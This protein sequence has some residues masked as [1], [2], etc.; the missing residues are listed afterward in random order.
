METLVRFVSPTKA[1]VQTSQG[2][3]LTLGMSNAVPLQLQEQ[4]AAVIAF[5]FDKYYNGD[6]AVIMGPIFREMMIRHCWSH[7][8]WVGPDRDNERE[9]IGAQIRTL[10]EQRHMDARDL[11]Q[12]A[13]LDASNL[14]RIEKGKYSAGLDILCKIA[15]ALNCTLEFVPDSNRIDSLPQPILEYEHQD[16]LITAKRSTFLL[17]E[18]L[19]QFGSFHWQQT[20]YNLHKGD[21]VYVYMSE[22]RLIKYKMTVIEADKPYNMWMANEEKY[23]VD[24]S[25]IDAD[26]SKTKYA[27]LQLEAVSKSGKLTEERLMEH[28]FLRAPQGVKHLDGDLLKFIKRK[29]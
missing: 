9:R 27:H 14:S 1:V 16:L 29:F 12:L 22:E 15:T 10:R 8:Y 13:D 28:G 24:H 4:E 17:D 26:E 25:R 11:A 19:Q 23:W 6:N 21:T 7:I 20:R 18:C 2:E 3:R 5:L